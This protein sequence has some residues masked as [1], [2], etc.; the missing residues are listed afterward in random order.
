MQRFL[1]PSD[2]DLT[3]SMIRPT[4][5]TIGVGLGEGVWLLVVPIAVV[6]PEC[7]MVSQGV[8]INARKVNEM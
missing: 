5:T 2:D 4:S 1:L 3:L 8:T 7:A 6:L